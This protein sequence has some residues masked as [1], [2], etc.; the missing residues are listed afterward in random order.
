MSVAEQNKHHK[1]D[2]SV[3][4]YSTTY[5]Y[6]NIRVLTEENNDTEQYGHKSSSCETI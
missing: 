5:T 1:N 3:Q 4:T 6:S 2:I